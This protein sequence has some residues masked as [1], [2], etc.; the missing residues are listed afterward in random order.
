[1]SLQ[2]ADF[3]ADGRKDIVTATREAT[4]FWVRRTAAGWDAPAHILDR[5]GKKMYLS[6]YYDFD[7]NKYDNWKYADEGDQTESGHHRVASLAWDIDA[8]GDLDLL[9][10]AKGG[11][12]Y[13]RE[14]L[15]TAKAPAFAS[16][17]KKMRAGDGLFQVPG[18]MTA[19][20]KVDWN[21]D[22]LD[23]LVCGSFAG[24]AY[25]YKNVGKKGAPSFAK[26][27]QLVAAK[28]GHG[29]EKGWYVDVTDYDGDGDL[30]L[31]VG[32]TYLKKPKKVE[33]S[34][35]QKKR[36][37]AIQMEITEITTAQSKFYEE[38]REKYGTDT[39]ALNDAMSKVVKGPEYQALNKRARPLYAEMRKLRPSARS[40][41]GIWL[42]RQH[43]ERAE[44]GSP[45]P[46]G[47]KSP[48]R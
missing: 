30:D 41:S 1:M 10:C 5:D 29:P 11:Q 19:A 27:V 21:G 16:F 18:G 39:D 32:G 33:L 35:A 12:L 45:A 8:D 40:T 48:Q 23:D 14:N 26:A 2:F 28:K 24:A 37:A 34:A 44:H 7:N 25:L 3:D 4:P 46:G 15:G 31:L 47:E 20:R 22:G 36:L 9:F 6:R 13:L 17:N 43:S 38:L 42:Y